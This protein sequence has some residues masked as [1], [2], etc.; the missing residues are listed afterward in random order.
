MKTGIIFIG[1]NLD[2]QDAKRKAVGLAQPNHK[3]DGIVHPEKYK[4]D[5]GNVTY[6]VLGTLENR[7][8]SAHIKTNMEGRAYDK[9]LYIAQGWLAAGHL[10]KTELNMFNPENSMSAYVR[11]W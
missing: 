8:L 5:T 4:P 6:R 2:P 10:V 7:K 3:K 9:A 1:H 11:A